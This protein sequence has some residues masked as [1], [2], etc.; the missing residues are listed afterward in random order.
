MLDAVIVEVGFALTTTAVGSDVEEQPEADVIVT[1]TVVLAVT[2]MVAV[3]APVD[4]KYVL[5]ATT[6]LALNVT[7]PP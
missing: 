7:D 3:V 4:H 2:L 6:G 1:V 5:P